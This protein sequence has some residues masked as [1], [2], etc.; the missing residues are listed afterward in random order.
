MRRAFHVVYHA[1]CLRQLLVLLA[2]YMVSSL[3]VCGQG[4][5]IS[6]DFKNTKAA[7]ALI[8]VER[9]SGVKI[10]FRYSDVNFLVTY[11][12]KK[13]YAAKIVNDIVGGHGLRMENKG[14]YLLVSQQK[15]YIQVLTDGMFLKGKVVDERGDPLIGATVRMGSTGE[16]TVTNTEGE[17]TL[18]VSA[19]QGNVSFSYIGYDDKVIDVGKLANMRVVKMAPS[20]NSLDDVVVTGFFDKTKN[21]F[22][23]AVSK[24][25]HDQIAEFGTQ[26]I[27][28]ILQVL[29]PSFKIK[30]NN[31]VG[32]NPNELPDFVIRG[33]SSFQGTSLPTIIVDGYET[34]IQYLYDMD[35]ERIESISILKDAS[36]TVYYGSRA[37]N[38]VIIIETRRPKAG[39]MLV[40]YSNHTGVTW[41]DL[42]SYK[43]MNASE[44]LE[45][46]QLAGVWTSTDPDAQFQ[47][48]QQYEAL[49]RNVVRGIDTYWISQPLR[50]GLTSTHSIYAEGGDNVVTYG[51]QAN[52]GINNGVMKGSDRRNLGISFD[53]G[54]RIKD[55]IKIRNAFSYNESKGN[56]SPYGS[57]SDYSSANPYSPIYDE[58]GNYIVSYNQH[59]SKG[60]VHYNPLYNASLPYRNWSKSSTIMENFSFD[61]RITKSLRWKI[62]FG[63][64]R[65]TGETQSYVS[66]NHSQFLTSSSNDVTQKGSASEGHSEDYGWD[67]ST[68]IA[69]NFTL[70]KHNIYVGGGMNLTENKSTSDSYRVTGFID[71]RFNEIGNAA[72]FAINSTPS[73]AGSKSRL[74]GFLANLNYS[75]GDR[76]FIDLSA[77]LDGSSAYGSD[78]RFGTLWSTGMGWNINNEKWMKDRFKWLSSLRLRGSYGVTGAANFDQSVART[79]LRFDQQNLY[80]E[81]LG[82]TFIQYGNTNL[83]WQKNKQVNIGLDF[84]IINRRLNFTFNYYVSNTD[85]LLLPVTTPLSMGFAQYTENFGEIENT[86]IDASLNAVII[87][88]KDFDWGINFNIG[89]NGN[90]IKKINDALRTTNESANAGWQADT[91][92]V[93][94]YEEGQSMSVIKAVRSLGINPAD[95]KEL[96]ITK[97]GKV[98]EV[99]NSDDKVVCGDTEPDF[100]GSFGTNV[101][102]KRWQLGMY[103]SYSYGAKA[104]NST[105]ASRIEG[106]NVY[107]NGDR[108]ALEDRWKQ[109]G[110]H[111]F[112]KNIADRSTSY[113]SSRFVQ[114]NNYLTLSNVALSYRVPTE[115]LKSKL[116]ITMCKFSVNMNDLFYAST[117]KQER[118]L[119][120]PF[121]RTLTFSLNLSF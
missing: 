102:W 19:T 106:L 41:A 3:S 44:K 13:E 21:T 39:K 9:K 82:A 110:D 76:Y 28:N 34:S 75:Y 42:T 95:G 30:E 113:T 69:N 43:L 7:T 53:I 86:G 33:E 59:G 46:E 100:S 25:S 20:S 65:T 87:R 38:G 72:R 54:Y 108:R 10:Q 68:T 57:F 79:M 120:Y 29:D 104:Y 45:F 112:Y 35:V 96:Y 117:I 51:M 55:K 56:N 24:I 5:R 67:L 115:W 89:H 73:S 52:Y 27:F 83:S 12:A 31:G 26:S 58:E 109:P 14:K 11:S 63:Y 94:E 23:G 97:D 81:T 40:S 92:P 62:N 98:T 6:V 107:E 61:Y 99:W 8:Q 1:D 77:R 60:T 4:K 22:T 32:S 50:K 103:F 64:S 118:G 47:L 93:T 91:R 17:Y 78:N 37:A 116:G 18:V 85:G 16:A 111:T 105:L 2:I 90:K 84:G 119:D 66:P 15:G 49:R 121:S 101:M 48:D 80:Y 36:A 114:D 70:G 71:D 88:K 74:V